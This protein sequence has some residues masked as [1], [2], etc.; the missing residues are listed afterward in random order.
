MTHGSI[1]KRGKVF[2]EE[3][4]LLQAFAKE[5]LNWIRFRIL[6]C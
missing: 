6:I 5:I 2:P 1:S 3:F 4:H